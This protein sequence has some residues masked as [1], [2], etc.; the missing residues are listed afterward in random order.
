MHAVRT[1]RCGEK[2]GEDEKDEGRER[3]YIR[4]I[5]RALMNRCSEPCN[6]CVRVRTCESH[7]MKIYHTVFITID[8]IV[9]SNYV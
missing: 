2:D 1:K 5:Q 3:P 8:A 6:P 7:G 9:S 4:R